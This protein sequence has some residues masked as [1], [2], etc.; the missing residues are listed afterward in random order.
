MPET[1]NHDAYHLDDDNFDGDDE[2]L[3]GLKERLQAYRDAASRVVA[4]WPNGDLA[5]AV[6]GLAALIDEAVT[7]PDGFWEDKAERLGFTLT[8]CAE[9]ERCMMEGD[10]EPTRYE[11]AREAVQSVEAVENVQARTAAERTYAATLDAPPGATP[12]TCGDCGWSGPFAA[13]AAIGD[14]A[15]TPGD[16]SP[17]GRCPACSTLAYVTPREACDDKN[18]D[19]EEG[20]VMQAAGGEL[21][22]LQAEISR[23]RGWLSFIEGSFDDGREGAHQALSGAPLPEGSWP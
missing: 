12:C 23:L 19:G 4:T 20:C 13:L 21:E 17:A 2:Q 18:I 16:P 6:R 9:G 7:L 1:M 14:C 11:T 8:Q 10:D 5:A 3:A 22:S 15:L